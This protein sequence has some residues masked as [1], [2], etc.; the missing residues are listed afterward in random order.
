MRT[1]F[2]LHLGILRRDTASQSGT[3]DRRIFHKSTTFLAAGRDLHECFERTLFKFG[4]LKQFR[5]V[6]VCWDSVLQAGAL[7]LGRHLTVLARGLSGACSDVD[8][9]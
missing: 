3:W 7:A 9:V 4:A 5:A 6:I 2:R 8:E 1:E